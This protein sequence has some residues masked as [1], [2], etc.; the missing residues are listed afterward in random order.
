LILGVLLLSWRIVRHS[1]AANLLRFAIRVICVA[2]GVAGGFVAFGPLKA[3]TS[4]LVLPFILA[5]G[6][7]AVLF[8]LTAFCL[9]QLAR[10]GDWPQR[11][12]DLL[13]LPRWCD[14]TIVVTMLLVFW[15]VVLIGVDITGR[16]ISIH[17]ASRAAADQS[18]VMRHFVELDRGQST[19]STA[20]EYGAEQ[21]RVLEA[22]AVQADFLSRFR[23]G[24]RQSSEK[25]LDATGT[26]TVL[27]KLD[28][29]QQILRL[30]PE[31]KRWLL[32]QNPQL[33]RLSDHPAI[34]RIARN[35]TLLGQFERVAEG[36]LESVYL[37]GDDPDVRQLLEDPDVR[38]VISEFDSAEVLEQLQN[39][40]QTREAE[41]AATFDAGN[42]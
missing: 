8:V 38:R 29:V 36:S 21:D 40:R 9:G 22:M 11:F 26:E 6:V 13:R 15:L 14:R 42:L 35:N 7:G 10:R 12:E 23:R 3:V 34:G 1:F 39:Y 30:S 18:L 31:E 19:P 2:F 4:N 20:T 32:R 41:T 25:V 28:Q 37:V 5:Y 27:I 24:L 16:L 33:L 17:S